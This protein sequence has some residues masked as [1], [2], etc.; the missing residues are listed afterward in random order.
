MKILAVQQVQSEVDEEQ[1][2]MKP[3]KEILL[4][5]QIKSLKT[6]LQDYC[7]VFVLHDNDLGR[8]F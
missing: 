3:C 8:I 1:E 4:A 6:T 7:D 5:E 2:L